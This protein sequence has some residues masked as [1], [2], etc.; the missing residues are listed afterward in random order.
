M[1][2]SLSPGESDWPLT[3]QRVI[4]SMLE[5]EQIGVSLSRRSLVMTPVK[6]TSLVLGRGVGPLG[7]EGGSHCDYC[8]IR[9]RCAYRGRRVAPVGAD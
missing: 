5:T 6:S 8:T 1:S 2:T 7:R 4:F 9:D 3:E